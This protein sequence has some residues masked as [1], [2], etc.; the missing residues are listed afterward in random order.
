M[1]VTVHP[2]GQYFLEDIHAVEC[3]QTLLTFLPLQRPIMHAVGMNAC[4]EGLWVLGERDQFCVYIVK[5]T[6]AN[7]TD[8]CL[9]QVK[10]LTRYLDPNAHG[11]INFKDFCHGVFAIKGRKCAVDV[12]DV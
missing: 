2:F 11:K 5:I 6:E 3:V 9:S 7:F 12:N 1:L 10:K 8:C 4:L